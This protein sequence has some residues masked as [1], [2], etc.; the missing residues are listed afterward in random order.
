MVQEEEFRFRQWLSDG[1]KGIRSAVKTTTSL[2]EGFWEHSW[3]AGREALLALRSL[4][5]AAIDRT[6]RQPKKVTKIKVKKGD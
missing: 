3:A 6:E 2:P 4:L 5:D 1:A